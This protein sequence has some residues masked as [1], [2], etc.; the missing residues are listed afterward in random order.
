V[1]KIR[2]RPADADAR[3][4]HVAA[5]TADEAR[6]WCEALYKNRTDV[7]KGERDRADH[8]RRQAMELAA[9]EAATLREA[10]DAALANASRLGSEAEALAREADAAV[11][12]VSLTTAALRELAARAAA[13]ADALVSEARAGGAAIP[14]ALADALAAATSVRDALAAAASTPPA[15]TAADSLP[16]LATTTAALHAAA[17][18]L[19]AA[20]AAATTHTATWATASEVSTTSHSAL[21]DKLQAA[22]A[23]TAAAVAAREADA[24]A[25]RGRDAAHAEREAKFS[26]LSQTVTARLASE[27]ERSRALAAEVLALRSR[28]SAGTEAQRRTEEALRDVTAKAAAAVEEARSTAAAAIAAASSAAAAAAAAATAAATDKAAA[29]ASMAPAS[30]GGEG[31]AAAADGGAGATGAAA[32]GADGASEAGAGRGAAG[33]DAATTTSAADAAAAAAAAVAA[34]AAAAAQAAAIPTFEPPPPLDVSSATGGDAGS[35]PSE[36]PSLTALD[37]D[38]GAL[39]ELNSMVAQPASSPATSD[40]GPALTFELPSPPPAAPTP[41]GTGLGGSPPT[42]AAVRDRATSGTSTGGRASLLPSFMQ[43]VGAG[44][45]SGSGIAPPPAGGGIAGS[46][47]TALPLMPPPPSAVG[48][49]TLTTAAMASAMSNLA[50]AMTGGAGLG[51]KG[52]SAGGTAGGATSAAA[53]AAAPHPEYNFLA[54]PH[55][56]RLYVLAMGARHLPELPFGT[57]GS[58]S[59]YIKLRAADQPDISY[60]FSRLV[61]VPPCTTTLT[62][63]PIQ[64]LCR[65]RHVEAVDKGRDRGLCATFHQ[66]A[67]FRV[68]HAIEATRLRL[69]VWAHRS[70]RGD[71]RV[72]SATLDC[73]M[74]ED[75]HGQPH[76]VWL[77]LHA[78]EARAAVPNPAEVLVPVQPNVRVPTSSLGLESAAPLPPPA[79]GAVPDSKYAMPD[80]PPPPIDTTP[81]ILVQLAYMPSRDDFALPAAH[82]A[83]H[84]RRRRHYCSCCC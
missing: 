55:P 39:S 56:G 57:F 63:T 11:G 19:R 5:E 16:V 51:G 54:D 68:T 37:T 2:P 45:G 7:L 1:L 27:K 81:S 84:R 53:A 69:E 61:Y 73:A 80:L 12:V 17:D 21:R 14:P 13:A 46:Y 25:A 33:G 76:A 28:V 71:V 31:A 26:A 23:A 74:L 83:V 34:V 44:L 6:E 29:L 30:S 8:A 43:R 36:A 52:G 42:A 49:A 58:K 15:A 62:H 41:A 64:L 24:E 9:L 22:E 50:A 20:T 4:L 75:W 77:M 47:P 48:G 70:F 82:H 67:T 10:R 35:N 3:V 18:A 78:D 79:A 59:C 60:V 40:H 65:G 32:A 66:P 38:D 72:G